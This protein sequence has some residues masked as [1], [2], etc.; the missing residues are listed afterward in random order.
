MIHL[1]RAPRSAEQYPYCTSAVPA[2][3]ACHCSTA[4]N[5]DG[6]ALAAACCWL[7]VVGRLCRHLQQRPGLIAACHEIQQACVGHEGAIQL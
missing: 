7:S 2:G 1:Q 5:T 4:G 3:R 6:Q